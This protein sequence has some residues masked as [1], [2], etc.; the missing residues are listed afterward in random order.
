MDALLQHVKVWPH[1]QDLLRD[2][3]K[4]YLK[5]LEKVATEITHTKYP[6]ILHVDNPLS[7]SIVEAE[8]FSSDIKYDQETLPSVEFEDMILK[9]TFSSSHQHI[10][11]MTRY[12]K[13][14][15]TRV[16]AGYA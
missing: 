1:P 13:F 16:L 6:K 15:K 7:P 10:F 8:E 5:H 2:G 4:C 14:G 12:Y 11:Q 3:S 9:R